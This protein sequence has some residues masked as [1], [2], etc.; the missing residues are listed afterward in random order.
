V[1]VGAGR[2]PADALLHVDQCLLMAALAVDEHQYLVRAERAQGRGPQDVGAVADEGA[3][4]IERRFQRLQDLAD[5]ER[6]GGVE[7]LLADDVDRGGGVL[8]G[9]AAD[10]RAGDLYRV[11]V[12]CAGSRRVYRT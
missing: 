1:D 6:A 7:L 11:E 10:A 8:G 2:A 9:A 4:E 3:G 12:G 5:L